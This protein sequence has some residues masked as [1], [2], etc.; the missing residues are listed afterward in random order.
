VVKQSQRRPFS[1]RKHKVSTCPICI[2]TLSF[3][4]LH[5]TRDTSKSPRGSVEETKGCGYCFSPQSFLTPSLAEN[6]ALRKAAAAKE[7]TAT[8]VPRPPSG[9]GVAGNGFNLQIAMG[10]EN[11]PDKYTALRVS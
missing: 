4:V 9:S 1:R 6:D 11:D 2:E 5:L 7:N 10:L 8:M 3:I